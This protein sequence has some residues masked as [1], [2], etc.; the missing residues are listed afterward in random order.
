[1]AMYVT[2]GLVVAACL[3]GTPTVR[4]V[5][6][7]Q[8]PKRVS[9]W[10]CAAALA[11]IVGILALLLFMTAISMPHH[12][13]VITTRIIA[14]VGSCALIYFMVRRYRSARLRALWAKLTPAD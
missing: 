6:A 5:D 10:L 12:S 4:A 11:W 9:R 13:L 1:V 2:Y 3:W 8:A 7:A 14:I